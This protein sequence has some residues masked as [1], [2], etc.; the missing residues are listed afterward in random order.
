[1]SEE[2]VTIADAPE[3]NQYEIHVDGT[4]AG[5]A[6]YTRTP[7]EIV[8]EHTEV[9]DAFEGRGLAGRLVKFALDDSRERG[10]HV[11][12]RCPY[13]RDYIRKHPEYADLTHRH[14]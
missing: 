11:I 3:R 4:L 1:M 7:G 9:E 5:V 13:V 8:Y 12:A 2:N 14:A 10:E 6:V